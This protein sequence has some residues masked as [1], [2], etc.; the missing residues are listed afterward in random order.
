MD[1][2]LLS[3]L[4][5]A[6]TIM[7]HYIFPPLSIG[8]GVLMVVMEGLYLHTGQKVYENMA[9]FWTGIFA[10]NFT[11]GVASGIVMEFQF[12]TNWAAYSRYVGDVFGSALAA[13]GIFAFF[14]ESSFLAV[15]VFGWD[16]FSKNMHFLATCLVS[17]GATFSATWI[18]IANS[19]QQTPTGYHIVTSQ[20]HTRAEITDFW[21]MVF[22]PSSIDRIIHVLLGA[23]ILSAFFVMSVCAYYILKNKHLDLAKKCFAIALIFGTI[24]CWLAPF[25]GHSSA[26]IV[27]MHQPAKLAAFEGHFNTGVG[28]LYVFGIPNTESKSVKFGLPIVGGLSFLVHGD[29]SKSIIGL[30]SVDVD[31]MP[32]VLIPFLSFHIMV[33]IGF[34]LLTMCTYACWLLYR[35]KL[36][37]TRWLLWC[38]VFSVVLP[39]I[40][41]QLGWIAAEVGRQP[42]LVYELL[43][44][45]DG[46]SE[47][48]K[49]NQVMWSIIMFSVI[50]LILFILWIVLLLDKIQKGP[51]ASLAATNSGL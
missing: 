33:G 21:A 41:N 9:R 18:V 36:F 19:W 37:N 29:F 20:G 50:Y 12:G 25:S 49:A 30:D 3:R 47:V 1:A 38:F 15:L 31:E 35:G 51:Q 42:W 6:L 14:L 45:S 13:E 22:N 32:P 27:A 46:L 11:L 26:R 7:F 34:G 16:K 10:L 2:L 40:A 39:F 44:T 43:K 17:L 28:D 5:F 4:Q 48:V 23:Y 8:L 24:S